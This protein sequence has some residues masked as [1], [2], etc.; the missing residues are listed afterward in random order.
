MSASVPVILNGQDVWAFVAELDGGLRIRLSVDDWERVGLFRGQCVPVRLPGQSEQRLYLAEAREEPPLVWV[1]LA[2]RVRAVGWRTR[3]P[4]AGE[5][6]SPPDVRP[7]CLPSPA[8]RA[9]RS[10]TRSG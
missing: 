1:V 5:P 7:R 10:P 9:T 2:R 6:V 8:T 4:G 3:P